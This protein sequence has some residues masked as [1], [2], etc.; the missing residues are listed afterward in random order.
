MVA[1]PDR[2]AIKMIKTT[3]FKFSLQ[4]YGLFLLLAFGLASCG[5]ESDEPSTAE[6]ALAELQA[7]YDEL[8]QKELDDPVKWAA[9]DL[10]NIGDWEYKVEVLPL[11]SPQEFEAAL[12]KLGDDRWEVIWMEKNTVGYT[13]FMKKP[14]IS[15]LN[16]IPLSSLGRFV[17]DD[18]G[19]QE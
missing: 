14:A 11:D 16:K 2:E 13:V 4:H 9:K 17:I 19:P 5:G 15:Y 3:G 18:S 12:N 7:K 1:A 10:E 6:K 8:S